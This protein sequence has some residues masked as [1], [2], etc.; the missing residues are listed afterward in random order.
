MKPVALITGA[1]R[2]IGAATSQLLASH[3]FDVGLVARNQTALCEVQKQIENSTSSQVVIASADVCDPTQV[4][5]AVQT[6]QNTL[7]TIT[8]LINNAGAVVRKPLPETSDQDWQRMLD[9][10]LN[11]TLHFIRAC[12]SD[13][14][15]SRGRV[16]NIASISGRQ[17]TSFF[18]G[19]CSAKHGVVGLTRALAEEFRSNKIQVN[20]ICPGSV[21]TVMLQ[22]GLPGA[23]PDMSPMD[24]AQA[25]LFLAK[26]APDALTGACIDVFG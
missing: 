20:A 7:G 5:T 1:S 14:K 17:G 18:S 25:T 21:D 9:V 26:H 16:I 24:V 15:T 6:I 19:Y 10:N 8:V 23:T 3:G 4:A 12:L 2:G 13:L 22:Q 11:G